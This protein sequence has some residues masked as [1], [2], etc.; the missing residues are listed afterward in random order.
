MF[1]VRMGNPQL[2]PG[3]LERG[4]DRLG[5][6]GTDLDGVPPDAQERQPCHFAWNISNKSLAVSFENIMYALLQVQTLGYI[7]CHPVSRCHRADQV[8]GLKSDF[9]SSVCNSINYFCDFS[10]GM[11]I[12]QHYNLFLARKFGDGSRLHLLNL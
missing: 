12:Y 5:S 1:Q 4:P 8:L 10:A 11:I 3:D 9:G 7:S 6:Q 2:L